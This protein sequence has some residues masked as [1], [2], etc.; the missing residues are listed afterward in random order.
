MGEGEEGCVGGDG[1][2]GGWPAN[3]FN[4]LPPGSAQKPRAKRAWRGVRACYLHACVPESCQVVN[5]TGHIHPPPRFLLSDEKY[6]DLF[7]E[8]ANELG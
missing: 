1:M 6:E 2:G 4:P 5:H 7:K 8:L 3:G